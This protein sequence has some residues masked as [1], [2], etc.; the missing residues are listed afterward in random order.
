MT[1]FASQGSPRPARPLT[2][3]QVSFGSIA[4]LT[5]GYLPQAAAAAPSFAPR[6]DYAT[7]FN[8]YSVAVGDFNA[9]GLVDLATA[10]SFGGN[11]V[12]LLLGEEGGTFGERKDYATSELPLSVAA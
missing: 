11:S 9:D 7:G 12:S 5:L 6:L 3:H 4:L 8:P 2:R 1:R 10:N